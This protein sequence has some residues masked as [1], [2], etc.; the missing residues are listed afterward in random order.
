MKT[1]E[2]TIG[3]A[4][5]HAGFELKE[6]IKKELSQSGYTVRDFGTNSNERVDYPDYAHPL[7]L[8]VESSEVEKGI[9][10]CGTGN[11]M[12][13]ALNRHKDIRAALCWTKDICTLARQHNNA[14]ICC[15]PARFVSTED[16]MDMVRTFLST[17]F[18]GGRH[19]ARINKINL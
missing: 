14:N 18:E 1:T 7:A 5:D 17:D 8:A 16:A 4:S 11:G 12:S 13:M 19:V 10:I 6:L 15:L 2:N 9:A 3:I